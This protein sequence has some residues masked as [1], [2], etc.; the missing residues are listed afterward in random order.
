[1][2][3]KII[4]ENI[5]GIGRVFFGG[6]E[7]QR[8]YHLSAT[9]LICLL[10]TFFWTTHVFAAITKSATPSGLPSNGLVLHHTFD[11]KKLNSSTST[12]S[13]V[14]GNNGSLLGG[15]RPTIG[16]V[17]QALSFNGSSDYIVVSSSTLLNLTGDVTISL[18]L[19]PGSTQS[20]NAAV[21][22]K[23]S[24]SSGGFTLQ[25]NNS[26]T[27]QYVFA[28]GNGSSY[29]CEATTTII[30]TANVW[31]HVMVVK[32]GSTVTGYVNGVIH[33]SCTGAFS[34]VSY[35]SDNVTLG[36]RASAGDRYWSG[37]MDDVRI[38]NR[39][40][41]TKE[42]AQL[43]G[44]KVVAQKAS[45]AGTLSTGLVG[46]WP[47][48]GKTIT[49]TGATTS[50]QDLIGSSHAAFSNM[51]TTTS[52]VRG[53]IGQAVNFNGST[54]FLNAGTSTQLA[55]KPMSVSFWAKSNVTTNNYD[56]PIGKVNTGSWTQGWGFYTTSSS[57]MRF[58]IQ[59]YDSNYALFSNL[60]PRLWHHY[61]GVWDGT[62][63]YLYVDGVRGGTTDTYTG[64][65]TATDYPM[66]IGAIEADI[67]YNW[68]GL[69][70]EVRVYNRALSPKEII[71]L[72]KMG[73]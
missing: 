12:D 68:D 53:K 21:L 70:D 10:L 23:Y 28:W 72:Y 15:Y 45:I 7:S 61:V 60:N 46:Y 31:Q 22:N 9:S 73:G 4:K 20:D 41:T 39:A 55:N 51:S 14:G 1:M 67:Y 34:T 30:L 3:I 29:T 19:K 16:K 25:Q 49:T 63:I 2:V 43:A 8:I 57:Q 56:S 32:S 48:D 6:S 38:Y 40:L 13:S 47:L 71:A 11:G 36:R 54:N 62:N 18:W 69:V 59:G 5:V 52:R 37:V 65:I 50:A 26:T 42:L 24:S 33:D 66:V 44:V 35:S 58:F 27:N 64:S 17:G